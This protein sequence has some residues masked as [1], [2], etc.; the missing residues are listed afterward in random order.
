MKPEPI[1]TQDAKEAIRTYMLF[2]VALPAGLV[3]L[4]A[5]FLG[6]SI[7]DVAISKANYEIASEYRTSI[8]KTLDEIHGD[9]RDFTEKTTEEKIKAQ[10]T[11]DEI[12]V[13]EEDA[14]K[15]K[16]SLDTLKTLRDSGKF[17]EDVSTN[18]KDNP[19]FLTNLTDSVFK[20][21]AIQE[22][23]VCFQ[24]TEGS[25]QCQ[26]NRNS[27]SAWSKSPN[28]TAKFRDDTDGRG[29]GCNYQWKMECR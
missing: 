21:G 16:L 11:F 7:K 13:L 5:F 12:K 23:R 4:G 15:I 26:G 6:Y 27:C 25:S 20:K 10:S 9:I 29:G 24:E 8:N 1:L 28:W 22:C 14:S 17:V 3:A 2:L 19:T 18:L